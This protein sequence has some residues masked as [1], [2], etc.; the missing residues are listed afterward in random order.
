MIFLKHTQDPP[1]SDL[2]SPFTLGC[3]GTSCHLLGPSYCAETVA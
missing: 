2:V 3:Q 1:Q